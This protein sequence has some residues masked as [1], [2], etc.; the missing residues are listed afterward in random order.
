MLKNLLILSF[1][2]LFIVSCKKFEDYPDNPVK[3]SE[4]IFLAHHGGGNLY[5]P[6]TK[7]ALFYGLEHM[8]GIE[9]DIQ[10]SRDNSLWLGHSVSLTGCDGKK[11]YFPLLTDDEIL[12]IKEYRQ[13][14]TDLYLLDSLFSFIS[15]HFP[16][17][18]ISLDVKAWTPVS[19]E[20]L[21]YKS[22]A[23]NLGEAIIKV[24]EKYSLSEHVMVESETTDLL[25]YIEENSDGIETYYLTY[26]D[27]IDGAEKVLKGGF[28]GIS[29]K[30]ENNKD[31]TTEDIF[32][33]HNK[34]LKLH[35]WT[36]NDTALI[37]KARQM[38]PDFIQ[39]DNLD[40]VCKI[41]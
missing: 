32:A 20:I 19:P 3:A 41:R 10:I 40:F 7:E 30:Y 28:T 25:E 38:E 14:D 27:Y 2:I 17:K 13:S 4:T 39:T 24:T 36:L 34:G 6:N 12:E 35:L 29:L 8:R 5:D 21:D 18:Y 31:L 15:S 33:I 1:I 9:C 26:G 23:E 16:D 22:R 11:K 37:I